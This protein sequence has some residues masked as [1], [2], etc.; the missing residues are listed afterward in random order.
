MRNFIFPSLISFANFAF[1]SS[2]R[3]KSEAKFIYSLVGKVLVGF[4]MIGGDA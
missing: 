3:F 4:V 2:V 1:S